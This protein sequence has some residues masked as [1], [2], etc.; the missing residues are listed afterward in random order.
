MADESQDLAVFSRMTA[1]RL[2]QDNLNTSEINV[3]SDMVQSSQTDGRKLAYTTG[4]VT[5]RSGTTLGTGSAA[6]KYIDDSGV[7]QD[8]GI[9]VTVRNFASAAVGTNRYII[10]DRFGPHYLV[11]NSECPS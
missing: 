7:I 1:L 5:A 8:E 6:L 4:G 3:P 10:V 11:A 9:T 2:L